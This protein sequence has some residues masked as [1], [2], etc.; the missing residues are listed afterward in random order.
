MPNRSLQKTASITA[1]AIMAALATII[2][3]FF[4]EIPLVPGVE[5]L[6]VDFSDIPALLLAMVVGPVPGF[7]VE[8]IKN[9]IHLLRSTTVGIGELL[10]IGIGAA[11]V[12][13]LSGFTG[14]FSRLFK[15]TAFHPQVYLLSAAL[16]LVLTVAAGWLLNLVLTPLYFMLMGIPVTTAS[17]IA[18]VTGSTVLN[19]V[20]AAINLLPFYPV[21]YGVDRAV[22]R[23]FRPAGERH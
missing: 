15:K 4:P 2:F 14:L 21:M 11:M 5:Y 22:G 8:I 7:L 20:K 18:G 12:F 6:K 13:G 3:M 19:L 9:V 17:V 1:T 23:L 10:N 16:T